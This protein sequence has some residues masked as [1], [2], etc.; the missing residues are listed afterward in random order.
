MRQ[1]EHPGGYR[2]YVV[3]WFWLFVITVLEVGIVL[4]HVPKV[5]LALSLVTMA[6]MKAALIVAYFMHLRY[7]RLNLIYAVVTPLFLGV[8]LFFALVPDA[9]RTLSLR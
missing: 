3:T 8:I 1:T 9:L 7:E 5:L 6:L 2:I 4:V